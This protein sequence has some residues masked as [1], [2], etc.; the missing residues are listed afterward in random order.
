MFKYRNIFE[1][2]HDVFLSNFYDKKRGNAYLV[3]SHQVNQWRKQLQDFEYENDI[4]HTKKRKV[5]VNEINDEE[6]LHDFI[7]VGIDIIKLLELGEGKISLCGGAVLNSIRRDRQLPK[8]YDF[9]FHCGSV[10]EA[11]KILNKCITHLASRTMYYA[12]SIGVLTVVLDDDTVIQFIQRVYKTKDQVLLGFDLAGCRYGWNLIDGFF[13]T[14]CGGIAFALQAFPID[15]TQRSFSHAYRL[16]KYTEKFSLLLPGFPDKDDLKTPDGRFSPQYLSKNNL[17]KDF[18]TNATIESDYELDPWMNVDAILNNKIHNFTFHMEDLNDI[19][20]EKCV[21]N[22]MLRNNLFYIKFDFKD[23]SK[24]NDRVI[25][26]FL[27]SSWKEFASAY[28]VERNQNES[29]RIWDE[30]IDRYLETYRKLA[31]QIKENPWRYENPG[32][33]NF[34]KM[35]PI[36]ADPREWYGPDYKPV[37]VG[38]SNERL[39]TLL[40]SLSNLVDNEHSL[41][42]EVIKIICDHWLKAEAMDARKRLFGIMIE[43]ISL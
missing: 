19:D 17:V 1:I 26:K 23:G 7:H 34:G 27:G 9:F 41:P 13:T 25:E 15:L 16:N 39:Y 14:I 42:Y 4:A 24:L 3:G 8:D 28:Y 12:R 31:T 18:R 30:C 29:Q 21:R 11:N 33:Q 38:I 2:I 32:G 36:I 10:E 43:N 40:H 37:I 22:S 35:N 20:T 5:L 6:I